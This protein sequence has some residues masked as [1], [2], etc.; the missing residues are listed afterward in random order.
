MVIK[1]LIIYLAAVLPMVF[2]MFVLTE[3]Q[4]RQI[5]YFYLW[6]MTA[7]LL[8][9]ILIQGLRITTEV[10]ELELAVTLT[11]IIEEFLKAMLLLILFLLYPEKGHTSLIS[12]GMVSG[13]GFSIQENIIYL[14]T[15][16]LDNINAVNYIITRVFSTCLMHGLTV[17][18]IG[19]GFL[20]LKEF[21]RKTYTV[22]LGFYSFA[23]VYHSLFNLLVIS[24][25]YIITPAI[26][27]G[28]FMYG[29]LYIIPKFK[30]GYKF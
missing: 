22:I 12:L 2:V 1:S 6:G 14:T 13:I 24:D 23:V 21:E 29:L 9:G 30:E 20:W 4:P 8:S 16:P 25:Y 19:F 17:A 7:S 18:I 26:S 15:M 28:I 3:K 10:S 27:V 11:P 5:V